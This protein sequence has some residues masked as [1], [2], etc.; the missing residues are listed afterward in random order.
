MGYNAMIL[1]GVLAMGTVLVVCAALS[2]QDYLRIVWPAPG[3]G[4]SNP[5]LAF[6]LSMGLMLHQTIGL[7]AHIGTVFGI[8]LVEGFVVTTL[9]AAVRLNRYLFEELWNAL[10]KG[11]APTFMRT[12]F[13]NAFLSV[14][15]MLWLAWNN[16]FTLLWPMF[17][18]A[19]QLLAALAL[20]AV[21]A[22]LLK[23]RRQAW[24]TI[25]P[26]IFMVATTIAALLLL[27][28]KFAASLQS[29]AAISGPL[30]LLVMAVLCLG[31]ALGLLCMAI[32]T[33]RQYWV[34]KSARSADV[35]E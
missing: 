19:N 20:I 23:K 27:M 21:S 18:T 30:T 35:S 11:K 9:D 6:A 5:I 10:F 12:T 14:A 17:A 16:G 2:Q 7:P 33:F 32:K 31:L 22:W 8:L 4:S 25:L 29:G 1:E 34:E 3:A 28:Q 26:A 13:F 24:F 15:L